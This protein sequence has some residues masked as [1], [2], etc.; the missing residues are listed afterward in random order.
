LHV[1]VYYLYNVL[2]T[3]NLIWEFFKKVDNQPSKDECIECGSVLSLG[4]DK[5][6]HQTVSKPD[7]GRQ[8]V[9][10]LDSTPSL[11]WHAT[12]HTLGGTK[13][14]HQK[15][16]VTNNSRLLDLLAIVFLP[17]DALLS[18]LYAVVVCLCVCVCHTPVLYQ[19]G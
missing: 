17:R 1:V 5:P 4:S 11:P 2:T 12:G 7:T 15:Y 16:F 3:K 6:R 14:P 13:Q 9:H 18:V 19:N 10:S 8:C